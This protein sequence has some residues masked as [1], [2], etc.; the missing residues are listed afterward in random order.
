MEMANIC[1]PRVKIAR[2]QQKMDQGDLAAALHVDFN[3]NIDQSDVSEIERQVRG[4]K[5]FELNAI[6][7]I[8][9]VSPSWLMRGDE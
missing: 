8:L 7:H 9:S 4:I 6:A 2:E 5:D 3:I 1:G